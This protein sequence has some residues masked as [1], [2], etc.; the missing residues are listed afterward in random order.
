MSGFVQA[1]YKIRPKEV[2]MI[3]NDVKHKV[4]K[5]ELTQ[6][7]RNE[8]LAGQLM[9]EDMKTDPE[10]FIEA[11]SIMTPQERLMGVKLEELATALTPDQIRE[12]LRLAEKQ[13]ADK[14]E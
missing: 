6:I 14:P 12:L 1:A 10:I 13:Q 4:D 3:L 9:L 11:L 5:G 2:I 7:R 8:I